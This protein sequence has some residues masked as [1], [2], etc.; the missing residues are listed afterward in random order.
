MG[1]V[2]NM[3]NR[4]IVYI[5][6]PSG[7]DEQAV[8]IFT[9][10]GKS[11]DVEGSRI[12]PGFNIRDYPRHLFL[13][14]SNSRVERVHT[15]KGSVHAVTALLGLTRKEAFVKLS[16]MISIQIIFSMMVSELRR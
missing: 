7:E 1:Q 6:A 2:Y 3:A 10:I 8:D 14:S 16:N 15:L 9:S 12:E 4:V 13:E 11:I 5:G